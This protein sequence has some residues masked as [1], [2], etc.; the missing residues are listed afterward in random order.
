M[1]YQDAQKLKII[2]ILSS[3]GVQPAKQVTNPQNGLQYIYNSPFRSDDHPSF[4]VTLNKNLYYDSGTG[5][6]G[7]VKNFLALCSGSHRDD[8]KS[9]LAW[10]DNIGMKPP[11]LFE[12]FE[13]NSP[14]SIEKKG[15]STLELVGVKSLFYYPLKNY[16][17]ERGITFEIAN[18]YLKEVVFRNTKQDVKYSA[19]GFKSGG[20]WELRK[21]KFKGTLGTG[22]SITIFE[23]N[24]SELLLFTGF[25]DF[26]SYLQAKTLLEPPKTALVLNS[27]RLIQKAMQYIENHNIDTVEYFKD[28]DDSGFQTLIDLKKSKAQIIDISKTYAKY[29]DLNEWLVSEKGAIDLK[30]K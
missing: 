15:N 6:G 28:N 5:E 1:R 12:P 22:K 26:L 4:V 10:A 21:R 25:F 27:D 20:T 17:A 11:T 9:G 19:I 8:I 7:N 13:R 3:M 29:K 16:I 23:K 2:D 30:A 18:K 14:T 24:T